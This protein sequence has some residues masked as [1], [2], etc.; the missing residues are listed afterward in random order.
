M[1]I[2]KKYPPQHAL[3]DGC[4]MLSLN[5]CLDISNKHQ[6]NRIIQEFTI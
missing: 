4:P 2:V 6:R 3:H 1:M 5:D